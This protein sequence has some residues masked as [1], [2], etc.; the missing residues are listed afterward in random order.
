MKTD[1]N[2]LE[3]LLIHIFM[4]FKNFKEFLFDLEK[5]FFWKKN[6]KQGYK[7]LF[8]TGLARSGTTSALNCFYKSSNFASLTYDD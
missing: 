6:F 2:F 4:N 3:K 5:F 1:H 7:C 8:I